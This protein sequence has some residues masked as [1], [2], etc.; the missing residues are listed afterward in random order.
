[1]TVKSGRWEPPA[2]GWL[3]RITSP[4]VKSPLNALI[5]YCT[6]SC[7]APKCTGMWGAFETRPPSGPKTAHE[8]SSRSLMLVEIEVLWSIL[9]DG[10]YS[11]APLKR[12]PYSS[13]HLPTHLFGD[14][15]K[16]MREDAE[17]NGVEI[18]GDSRSHAPANLDLHVPTWRDHGRTIRLHQQRAQ[19]I[20]DNGG[21]AYRVSG[22]QWI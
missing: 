16:A 21:P 15:H 9:R 17:L 3:E 12:D 1:M 2:D 6:V 19:I 13:T 7:I 18:S 20:H 22:R 8:K 10:E 14:A 5:W 4:G 11:S